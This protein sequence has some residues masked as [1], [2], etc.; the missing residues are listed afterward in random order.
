MAWSRWSGGRVWTAKD[1]RKTYYGSVLGRTVSTRKD[2]ETDA[3]A[4]LLRLE[5]NAG[6][7]AHPL[8]E[9][10]IDEYVAG[11]RKR[12]IDP[13]SCNQKKKQLD[14]WA[15]DVRWRRPTPGLLNDIADKLPGKRNRIACLKAYFT[16][17]RQKD[18]LKRQN[19]PTIDM[20]KPT[21][22]SK[23]WNRLIPVESHRKVLEIIDKD[24][25]KEVGGERVADHRYGDLLRVLMGTGLHVSELLRFCRSGTISGDVLI[26]KHKKGE[27]H[28]VRVSAEVLEAAK[29]SKER[30][31]FGVSAFYAA[32][33]DACTK[34]EVP[35]FD[36]GGYRH[37]VATHAVESGATPEDVAR[38]LGHKSSYMVKTIYAK[39]VVPPKIPTME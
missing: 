18:R 31:G 13:Q 10:W 38:F 21:P 37:T 2:N 15:T 19:D 30:G 11:C 25:F 29:R 22:K 16:W 5:L 17:L 20:V 9:R 32:V 33:A 35:Q 12:G 6:Q 1:G 24:R 4:E 34:A 14:R 3:L 27:P 26:V 39:T 36:P 8:N 7:P 23:E 28:R